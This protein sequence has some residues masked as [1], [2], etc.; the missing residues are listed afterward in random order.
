M[1]E[2]R[3][4]TLDALSTFIQ[5][6]RDL[7][8]QTQSDITRLRE[9][10]DEVAEAPPDSLDDV[11]DKLKASSTRLSG[12]LDYMPPLPDDIDW[13]LFKGCDPTPLKELAVGCRQA[14]ALRNEPLAIQ[15]SELSELQ[16]LVK[17][18]RVHMVDPALAAY[19]YLAEM[20][21]DEEEEV[22]PEVC[23]SAREREKIRE[24]K[25]RRLDDTSVPGFGGLR[26]PRANGVFVRRDQADESAEVDI[27]CN[28]YG[29]GDAEGDPSML[30]SGSEV[31]PM[32]VDTPPTSVTSPLSA[33]SGLPPS[34][35]PVHG[36]PV[37]ERRQTRKAKEA[38]PPA[39]V[40]AKPKGRRE[41]AP[42]SADLPPEPASS[43]AAPQKEKSKQ[44][45]E[46]YKQAWSVSEQH[47]LE[48]LLEEIPEGEKNRWLKISQAMNSRRTARQVASRVQKYFEKLKRFGLDVGKSTI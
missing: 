25:K 29:D 47:L 7:L 5:S 16:K 40:R 31:V 48:R 26:R 43:S 14:Y 6:Q 12:Q 17:D 44:K 3:A 38:A 21:E 18:A 46:T 39:D 2:K 20:S 22:D 28:A 24:L 35:P 32:D 11:G 4:K 45:S 42:K 13:S 10:R 36:K 34:H 1:E 15:H 23:R 41:T 9:L 33:V 8:A 30:G 19:S 27:S 37:R